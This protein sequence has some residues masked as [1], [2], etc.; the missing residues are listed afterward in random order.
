MRPWIRASLVLAA[1]LSLAACLADSKEAKPVVAAGDPFATEG[2]AKGTSTVDPA[3]ATLKK[4][5]ASIT[6]YFLLTPEDS[7]SDDPNV[8]IRVHR[9]S[10]ERRGRLAIVLE[11]ENR[12]DAELT[13]VDSRATLIDGNDIAMPVETKPIETIAAGK[14]D[15]LVWIFDT[16]EAAKGSMEMRMEIAGLKTWPVVFSKEKPPDF[17]PTPAPN[18]GQ[19]P[20][21]GGGPGG[22]GGPPG[23]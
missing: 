13:L 5:S 18:E 19:D 11:V 6:G 21:H 17:K 4:S 8:V 1:A 14:T 22:L 3:V 10:K 7:F 12:R 20:S 16:N 9:I 23:Y 15:R 2:A